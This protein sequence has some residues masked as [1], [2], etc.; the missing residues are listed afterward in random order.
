M[1]NIVIH[2]QYS[3]NIPFL[4]A[5]HVSPYLTYLV[6]VSRMTYLTHPTIQ[7][8]L[9]H[10]HTAPFTLAHSVSAGNAWDTFECYQLENK[11]GVSNV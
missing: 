3:K 6:H 4:V 5:F 7:N 9:T 8:P 11:L 1:K 10:L 2:V